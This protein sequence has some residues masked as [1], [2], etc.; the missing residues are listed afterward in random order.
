MNQNQKDWTNSGP[1]KGLFSLL[2]QLTAWAILSLT[3]FIAPPMWIVAIG[4]TYVAFHALMWAL[5]NTGGIVR[6]AVALLGLPFLFVDWLLNQTIMAVLMLDMPAHPIEVITK[7]MERYLD[8]APGHNPGGW[9]TR[10]AAWF[11]ERLRNAFDS[12]MGKEHCR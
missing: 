12:S 4:L 6:K 5:A 9:R 7:R 10:F 8:L 1:V 3:P 2:A 11:C